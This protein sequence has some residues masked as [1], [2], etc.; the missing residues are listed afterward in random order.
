M[1]VW[2]N[3]SYGFEGRFGPHGRPFA[4]VRR[5]A[6]AGPTRW[7]LEWVYG[8]GGAGTLCAPTAVWLQRQVE[9]YARRHAAYIVSQMPPDPL[10][11]RLSAAEM[12]DAFWPGFARSWARRAQASDRY[13][14]AV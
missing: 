6:E 4:R 3:Y 12:D 10:T 13:G 7:R 2:T 9:A 5:V 14:I 8:P 11:C 1:I